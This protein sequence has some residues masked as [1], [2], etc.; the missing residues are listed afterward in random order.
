ML[1]NRTI[2]DYSKK[3]YA[4]D[5]FLS[6]L[7]TLYSEGYNIYIG[8]DSKIRKDKVSLVSCLVLHKPSVG[9]R[10]FYFNER[11]NKKLCP[12]LRTR[13]LLE[14][15]RSIELAMDIEQLGYEVKEIHLDVGDT[16]KSKTSAYEEELQSLILGQGYRCAIKPYS[17]ASSAVADKFL[18][19]GKLKSL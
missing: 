13:M 5:E 8:S 15:H 14:A 2:V 12:N 7:K 17:W 19:K 11:L 9:A 10:I 3:I 18:R 6:I 16:I 1:D 4:K